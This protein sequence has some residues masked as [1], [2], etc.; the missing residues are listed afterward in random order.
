MMIGERRGADI[1]RRRSA[2]RGVLVAPSDPSRVG[3]LHAQP[4]CNRQRGWGNPSLKR[5]ASNRWLKSRPLRW[6]SRPFGAKRTGSGEG[7][8]RRRDCCRDMISGLS[9]C[10]RAHTISCGAGS[11]DTPSAPP[12][13]RLHDAPAPLSSGAAR[14]LGRLLLQA[15]APIHFPGRITCL[16]LPRGRASPPRPSR[17][18][19]LPG[20]PMRHHRKRPAL[21]RSCQW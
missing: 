16:A 1:A 6:K 19:T 20:T 14:S 9:L 11:I 2:L 8:L 3:H 21:A 13:R 15:E 12:C 17:P 18:A 10:R 7:C 4:R 5:G